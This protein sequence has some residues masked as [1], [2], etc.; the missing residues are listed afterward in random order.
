LVVG[1]RSIVEDVLPVVGKDD[2]ARCTAR[3]PYIH[4]AITD[5][6]STNRFTNPTHGK[7]VLKETN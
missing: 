7:L 6:N 1:G 5:S 2:T 3:N 4:P